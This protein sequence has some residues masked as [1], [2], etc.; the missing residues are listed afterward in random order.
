MCIH[1]LWN[2][3]GCL[4]IV[5][6]LMKLKIKNCNIKIVGSFFSQDGPAQ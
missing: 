6:S 3:M 5:I 4:Y 2:C 1:V